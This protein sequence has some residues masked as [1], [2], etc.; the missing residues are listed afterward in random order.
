MKRAAAFL[1]LLAASAYAQT[2]VSKTNDEMIKEIR[3]ALKCSNAKPTTCPCTG[4]GQ[5]TYDCPVDAKTLWASTGKKCIK[6]TPDKNST[7][8]KHDWD[9][10]DT[11]ANDCNGSSGTGA[12]WEPGSY[13]CTKVKAAIVAG[14]QTYKA[15]KFEQ[16]FAG[17]NTAY[18]SEPWCTTKSCYVDPCKCNMKDLSASSWFKKTDGSKMYYS[19]LKCGGAYEFKA[20]LCAGKTDKTGC[21]ADTGC[22]WM[23][24]P[25][26]RSKTEAETMKDLLTLLKCPDAKPTTCKCTGNLQPTYD[27]PVDAKTLWASTGKQCIKATPDKDS[28]WAKHDWDYPDTTAKDCSGSSGTG[29]NWEPGSYDCTKVKAAIVAE[30]QTY[31]AH[32]F[33]QSF[34]GYNKA[35]DSEAWCT[36]KSCY[37]DPCKCNMKDM[38]ASSWFK[39]TDG[40]KL[41]YSGMKCGETYTFKAKLCAGKKTDTTCTTDTGC[42]WEGQA[43]PKTASSGKHS[44][45]LSAS[46]LVI[47]ATLL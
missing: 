2:C 21:V 36:Q 44:F 18:D 17:Y 7:W 8:A 34:A 25:Y 5:T 26:C 40:S 27:C 6:A 47:G 14:K 4:N 33:E 41:Y 43:S 20:A 13:D 10:P 35:Y 28:T 32:K 24:E 3:T 39:K 38:S 37:V 15:H 22:K 11:T 45:L 16:S 29:A 31:K 23:P 42:S 46:A 12:N 19:G 1:T 9:Y 30:K